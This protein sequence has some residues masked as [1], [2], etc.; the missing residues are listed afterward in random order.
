M[1]LSLKSPLA[2]PERI[3]VF[4]M[5]GVGKSNN[6]LQLARKLPNRNFYVA[7]IDKS[8]SYARALETDYRDLTNVSVTRGDPDDWTDM[9]DVARK[10]GVMA[11]PDDWTVADSASPAWQGV[12]NWYLGRKYPG[13]GGVDGDV[14][15]YFSGKAK[16]SDDIDWPFVNSQYAKFTAALFK[17]RG[18]L[19]LTA[20]QKALG[21][22]EDKRTVL[23]FGGLGVRPVGQKGLGHQVQTVLHMSCGRRGERMLTTVKDRN[24]ERL[25]MKVLGAAEGFVKGYVQEVAGWTMGVV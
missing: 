5:E 1:P 12:Q 22:K 14:E 18:H 8:P 19:Y 17:S 4:G 25:D 11:G 3:L 16:G 6:V 13:K 7:D 24:R 2:T 15:D 20:E 23:L 21:E 10:V 9:L